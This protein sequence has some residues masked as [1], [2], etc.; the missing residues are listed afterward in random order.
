MLINLFLNKI[1]YSF[2]VVESLLI[3]Y[4][5]SDFIKKREINK[6]KVADIITLAIVKIK[7]RYDKAYKE[8]RL[9]LKNLAYIY[10]YKGFNYLKVYY[11]VS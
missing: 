5:T 4:L 9:K 11:K 8:I 7:A 6:K 2:K 1:I 3:N 10:L